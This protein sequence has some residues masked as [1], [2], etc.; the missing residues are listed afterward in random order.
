MNK[1][2]L[3]LLTVVAVVMASCKTQKRVVTVNS[4]P[5]NEMPVAVV[6]NRPISAGDVPSVDEKTGAMLVREARTW[7]G[8]P[9]LYGGETKD[10]ADCSG[11]LMTL[12]KETCSLSLPRNSAAQRDYCIAIDRPM[13]QPGDLVFF[14][15]SVG[16]GK[17]SHVGMYIGSG[18]MIHA[19]TSRGVIESGLDEKY[20]QNHYHSSGRVYGITNTD[21]KIATPQ[22]VKSEPVMEVSLDDFAASSKKSAAAV[23]TAASDS[24]K[25]AAAD[26]VGVKRVNADSI[27]QAEI[28]ESVRKAMKF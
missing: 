7:I 26:S 10:G 3:L 24:V 22:V 11:F 4:H 25:V 5:A 28:R 16:Q 20:Y 19:S 14:S 23:K 6:I 18:K 9:Y 2:L 1:S 21:A 12:F 15:S 13:L 17:V 27:R 8:T